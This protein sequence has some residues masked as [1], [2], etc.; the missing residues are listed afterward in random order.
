MALASHWET[1]IFAIVSP[2]LVLVTGVLFTAVLKLRSRPASLISVFVLGYAS[3]VFTA[4]TLG[5]SYGLSDRTYWIA[6]QSVWLLIA[7]STWIARR[8]PGMPTGF[9]L[10]GTDAL[11]SA[12]R[13]PL[14]LALAAI[15]ACTY[16]I[17]A[18]L[19]VTVPP[20]NYDGLSYHLARVA[21]WLQFDSLLP[22][23]TNNPRQLMFPMN[24]EIGILW[25]FLLGEVDRFAGFVQWVSAIASALAVFGMARL[26]GFTRSRSAFPALVF[27]TL[28]QVMLQSTTVQNDLV[29]GAFFAASIYMLT[30]GLK[31]QNIGALIVSGIGFGLGIGTKFTA[32]LLLPGMAMFLAI[33]WLQSRRQR[34]LLLAWSASAMAGVILFGSFVYVLNVAVYGGPLGTHGFTRPP[35]SD[36]AMTDRGWQKVT[37]SRTELVVVNFPRYLTQFLD[38]S[39]FQEFGRAM[40]RM[41]YSLFER[42]FRDSPIATAWT[43]GRWDWAASR[44]MWWGIQEDTS[45]FGPLGALV[46]LPGVVYG[47]WCGL[48]RRG[49][50]LFPVA[51]MT[52]IFFVVASAAQVYTPAKGRY[53]VLCLSASGVLLIVPVLSDRPLARMYRAM[54]VVLAG[55]TSFGNALNNV[56][57]PVLGDHS[58]LHSNASNPRM[59]DGTLNAFSRAIDQTIA[60]GECL[61]LVGGMDTA[62]YLFFGRR[63]DLCVIPVVASDPARRLNLTGLRH[64]APRFLLEGRAGWPSQTSDYVVIDG[65]SLRGREVDAAGFELLCHYPALDYYFFRAISKV[66]GLPPQAEAVYDFDETTLGAGWS[67]PEGRAQETSFRWTVATNASVSAVRLVDDTQGYQVELRLVAAINDRVL[68]SLR[69]VA[70]GDEIP[71]TRETNKVYSGLIPAAVVRAR[72]GVLQLVIH[73]DDLASP[74]QLGIGADPRQLGVAVDAIRVVPLAGKPRLVVLR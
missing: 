50:L 14:T 32:A 56:S 22:W 67:L 31:R 17:G 39:S 54:V 74:E 37:Y 64:S 28:T 63:R 46:F 42:V 10:P 44:S 21:Y 7:V 57:K 48:A 26:A 49:G 34:G 45:W 41:K 20:N 3:I 53:F 33:V 30:F 16:A 2:F 9:A 60:N 70:N 52:V 5:S 43:H 15:V 65:T 72:D 55:I 8:R 58:I 68:E 47:L 69:L 36:Y 66:Q 11:G 4:E 23:A 59:I 40:T 25:T 6:L 19:I 27:L 61:V 35:V 73:T 62:E 18:W 12:R 13:H 71:L 38:F 51:A 1:L 29:I 24:A